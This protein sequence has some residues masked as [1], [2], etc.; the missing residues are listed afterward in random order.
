MR[1]S[2]HSRQPADQG[3]RS[4]RGE[5]GPADLTTARTPTLATVVAISS[6]GHLPS[7]GANLPKPMDIGA[8]PLLRNLTSS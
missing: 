4:G 5:P 8:G 2:S 7:A 1:M 6:P 3:A